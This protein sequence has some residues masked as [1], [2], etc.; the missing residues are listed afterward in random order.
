[1]AAKEKTKYAILRS[2]KMII[3][4]RHRQNKTFHLRIIRQGTEVHGISH[5]PVDTQVIAYCHKRTRLRH[6]ELVHILF[7]AVFFLLAHTE[8]GK[9]TVSFG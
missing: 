3:K 2:F 8:F 5:H 4:L 9:S 7:K 6:F 1:M